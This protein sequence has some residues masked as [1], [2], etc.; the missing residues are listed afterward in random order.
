MGS[1]PDKLHVSNSR[2]ESRALPAAIGVLNEKNAS[3]AVISW[4]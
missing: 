1:G 2:K 4:K 3:S